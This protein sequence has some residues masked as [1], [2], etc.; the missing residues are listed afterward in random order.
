MLTVEYYKAR[1][2]DSKFCLRLKLRPNF[3]IAGVVLFDYVMNEIIFTQ[4]NC[5]FKRVKNFPS[6]FVQK[7]F[8]S[9]IFFV[10]HEEEAD[11]PVNRH[12][13]HDVHAEE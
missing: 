9:L 5:F 13:Q 12:E 8:T 10:A 11:E 2:F 4:T 7:I 6:D 1:M 3:R